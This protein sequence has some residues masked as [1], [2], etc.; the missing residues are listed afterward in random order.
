MEDIY[1]S[2]CETVEFDV[3]DTKRDGGWKVYENAE[4]KLLL[5][6]NPWSLE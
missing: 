2:C 5:E 6:E 3:D 1:I 4:L